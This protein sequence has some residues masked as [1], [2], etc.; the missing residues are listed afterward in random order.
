M[1]EYPTSLPRSSKLSL[2]FNSMVQ[3]F[4]IFKPVT[5]AIRKITVGPPIMQIW[6]M[7]PSFMMAISTNVLHG[8]THWILVNK[9]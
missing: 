1:T 2:H 8:D 7:I 5:I 9:L 6:H 3:L 4:S